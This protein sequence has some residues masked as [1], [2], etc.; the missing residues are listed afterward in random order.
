MSFCLISLFLGTWCDIDCAWVI[1]PLIP[2]TL[3]W[4]EKWLWDLH[5]A[6]VLVIV[7]T[8]GKVSKHSM[9]ELPVTLS[10][11]KPC[12]ESPPSWQ[13]L[14]VSLRQGYAE[15]GAVTWQCRI[16]LGIYNM[17]QTAMILCRLP[18]RSHW[19]NPWEGRQVLYQA[20][21][22][23]LLDTQAHLEPTFCV[24][25]FQHKSTVLFHHQVWKA[26]SQ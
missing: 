4:Y 25:S 13:V 15:E 12:G 20:I 24:G 2:L 23:Q 11:V 19:Q 26:Q 6:A 14:P 10:C 16:L 5:L 21:L 1:Y 8:T 18:H 17:D 7:S 9:R 22:R 3:V